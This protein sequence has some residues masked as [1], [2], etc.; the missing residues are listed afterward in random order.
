[1]QTYGKIDSKYRFVIVAAKRAKQLLKGA[2]PKIKA[3]TKNPIR[4]AQI[5]VREGR[6]EFDILHSHRED[7]LEPGEQVVL[8]ADVEEADEGGGGADEVEEIETEAVVH[9]EEEH[10]FVEDLPE[11]DAGDEKDEG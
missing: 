8:A 11:V 5:E 4:I 7:I 9:D 10:G 3:K 6:I 2:K 1:V